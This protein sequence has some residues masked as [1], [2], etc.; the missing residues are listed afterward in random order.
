MFS[1]VAM[2][3]RIS[4]EDG[5]TGFLSKHH[6]VYHLICLYGRAEQLATLACGHKIAA[7]LPDGK[8]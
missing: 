6:G 7:R 1:P 2:T 8:L 4:T 5:T 3:A